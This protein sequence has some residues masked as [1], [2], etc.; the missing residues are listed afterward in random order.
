MNDTD[1]DDIPAFTDLF[2]DFLQL[3]LRHWTIR[4]IRQAHNLTAI[5]TLSGCAWKPENVTLESN[6]RVQTSVKDKHYF[7]T[8]ELVYK[9]NIEIK[10]NKKS[11]ALQCWHPVNNTK[12]AVHE[13]RQGQFYRP[14]H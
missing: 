7:T 10:L 6:Q 2:T 14:F 8:D 5:E 13:L 12:V 1:I 9:Y 11:P 3:L 4:F